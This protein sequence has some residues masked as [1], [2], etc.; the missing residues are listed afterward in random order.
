MKYCDG[1]HVALG[2][3]V[4]LWESMF[5]TIVCSIDDDEYT[6]EFSRADWGHVGHG[7]VIKAD[8]GQIFHYEEPDED[9][10][11]LVSAVTPRLQDIG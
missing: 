8:D 3:R 5:G 2:D 4:R 11:L 1:T 9:L 6:P 10:E 7:V